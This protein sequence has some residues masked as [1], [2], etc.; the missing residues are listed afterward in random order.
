MNSLPG[1]GMQNSL[2]TNPNYPLGPPSPTGGGPMPGGGGGYQMANDA[3]TAPPYSGM[4]Q[5]FQSPPSFLGPPQPAQ[6]PNAVTNQVPVVG[7]GRMPPTPVPVP[8]SPPR[9]VPTSPPP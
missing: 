2:G 5:S 7:I 4:G 1:S 6:P 8:T 3:G 9:P